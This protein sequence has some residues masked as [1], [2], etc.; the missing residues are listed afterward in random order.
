MYLMFQ[1]HRY[2]GYFTLFV[3]GLR[4]IPAGTEYPSIVVLLDLW[5]E[6]FRRFGTM[7]NTSALRLQKGKGGE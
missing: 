1:R 7:L 2:C 3:D 6:I 4:I 5:R